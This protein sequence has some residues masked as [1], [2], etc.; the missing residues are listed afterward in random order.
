MW[1]EEV[2]EE[3]ERESSGRGGGKNWLGCHDR[4]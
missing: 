3:E 4:V 2:D 1:P